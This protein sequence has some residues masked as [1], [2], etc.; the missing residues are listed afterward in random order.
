LTLDIEKSRT[1]LEK[2]I[3]MQTV[4]M[5]GTIGAVAVLLRALQ[6]IAP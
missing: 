2:A 3:R 5:V 1:L 4:W 6:I